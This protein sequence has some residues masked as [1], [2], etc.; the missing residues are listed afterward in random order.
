MCTLVL[1]VMEGAL[2]VVT[3]IHFGFFQFWMFPLLN[4]VLS[5]AASV[6]EFS[7]RKNIV[8]IRQHP[9]V[10][11]CISVCN[12]PRYAH[13]CKAISPNAMHLGVLSPSICFSRHTL[14]W[15]M[16]FCKHC[17]GAELHHKIGRRQNFK[18]WLCFCTLFQKIC[19][20]SVPLSEN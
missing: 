7:F 13:F 17:L 1:R 18:G 6:C 9:D 12:I 4:L 11:F 3:S 2:W 15:C 10:N 14:P 8:K 16:H 19:N 20:R 5:I